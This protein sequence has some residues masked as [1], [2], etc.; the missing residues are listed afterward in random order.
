MSTF[1]TVNS[2]L[3]LLF[4]ACNSDVIKEKTKK[5]QLSDP[6]IVSDLTVDVA[7]NRRGEETEG[8]TSCGGACGGWWCTPSSP[9]PPSSPLLPS[10]PPS[11]S[12][13]SLRPRLGLPLFRRRERKPYLRRGGAFHTCTAL[14]TLWAV[15]NSTHGLGR[16][17]LSSRAEADGP[18]FACVHGS[19]LTDMRPKA[20]G[21]KKVNGI[22]ATATF[23]K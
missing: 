8:R 11:S 21:K 16:A 18:R 15:G 3:K 5:K 23:A 4:R 1:T 19:R 13:S 17:T 2:N 22:H 10:S 6:S 14:S 12:P 7:G 20:K 9:P